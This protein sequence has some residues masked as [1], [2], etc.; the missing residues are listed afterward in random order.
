MK[1]KNYIKENVVEFFGK[2][3]LLL[4]LIIGGFWVLDVF[5][6]PSRVG[7]ITKLTSKYDWFSLVGN[8]L[9]VIYSVYFLIVVT[10][11]DR[12]DN[13]ENIRQSQRPNLCTRLYLPNNFRVTDTS[14]EGYIF[15]TGE[16]K[17][18]S[19]YYICFFIRIN[20]QS[21]FIFIKIHCIFF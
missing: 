21:I 1:E 14:V 17:N 12:E 7:L 13:N 10:R 8:F 19:K 11:M 6:I 16:E 5:D 20:M 15:Q 9:S 4:F 3:L 2:P 18:T